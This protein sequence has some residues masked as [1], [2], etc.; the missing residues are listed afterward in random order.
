M[1]QGTQRVPKALHFELTEYAALL[2]ALRVRDAMDISQHLTKPNPFALSPPRDRADVN[3]ISDDDLA[4][5]VLDDS[6]SPEPHPPSS[7]ASYSTGSPIA[8][9]SNLNHPSNQAVAPRKG[10]RKAIQPTPPAKAKQKKRDHWTRWPL[11]LDDVLIPEW[12]LED[13]VA[14]IASQTLR[15]G[16]KPSFPDSPESPSA[17]SAQNNAEDG[18]AI[19]VSDLEFD[20][21]DPDHPFF[22]PD[23]TA[24]IA[25]F[26]QTIFSLL[27]KHTIPRPASMQNRIEP[28]NWRAVLDVIVSCGIPEYSNANIV[29][30]VTRRLEALY[31]L[32]F[33]PFE[34]KRST[35]YRAVERMRDK[36]AALEKMREMLREPNASLFRQRSPRPHRSPTPPPSPP[37]KKRKLT[38]DDR[39]CVPR[40]RWVPKVPGANVEEK[41]SQNEEELSKPTRR[42]TRTRK[43]IRY[44]FQVEDATDA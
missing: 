24:I 7:V 15:F 41:G 22:V 34:S 40:K 27:A 3:I 25:D 39:D 5:E 18:E 2:R 32:S 13:E 31:G 26:L 1:A 21:E 19:T 6:C 37:L 43:E 44:T 4:E 35:S 17:P 33:H 14:V 16:P 38:K 12:T 10:K 29:E 9:P 20:E 30:N 11:M 42:S 8:G 36:E 23:L 28:L